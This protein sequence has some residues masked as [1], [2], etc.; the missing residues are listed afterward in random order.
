LPLDAELTGPY[1]QHIVLELEFTATEGRITLRIDRLV[2]LESRSCLTGD[3]FAGI[4]GEPAI[5]EAV[6]ARVVA[7]QFET[8]RT[9]RAA[10]A[11]FDRLRGFD[12]EIG[13]PMS[14]VVVASWPPR[15]NSSAGFARV[16]YTGP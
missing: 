13:F 12:P 8:E 7:G 16:R 5:D 1:G 14:N 6:K 10:Q 11:D 9:G 2:E 15:E 4:S 3:V